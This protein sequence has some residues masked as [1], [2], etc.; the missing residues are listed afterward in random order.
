[1]RAK[2]NKNKHLSV[3]K[4]L[5]MIKP[6]L[7]DLINDHKTKG[8]WKVNSGNRIIDYKTQSEWKIQLTMKINFI[9]SK[10]SEETRNMSTKIDN[11]E[12]MMGSETDEIIEELFESLL[13]R[14]QEGLEESM[15]GSEFVL[16]SVDLLHYYLQKISQMEA[17]HM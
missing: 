6:Y 16:D 5:R 9:S 10:E 11:I 17:D 7:R 3:K 12:I 2:E 15:K 1:M 4:Y 14:Y 13:Q 8:V